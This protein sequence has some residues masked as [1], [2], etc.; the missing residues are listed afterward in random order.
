MS[1]FPVEVH[2]STNKT[3]QRSD[4]MRNPSEDK[5]LQL[6]KK[7]G[8]VEDAL[9]AGIAAESKASNDAMEAARDHTRSAI[10]DIR[11]SRGDGQG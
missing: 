7:L 8:T 3:H 9:A 2:M 10:G 1:T 6:E 4:E 5:Y 11:R